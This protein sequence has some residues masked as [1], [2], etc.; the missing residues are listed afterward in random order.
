[1]LFSFVLN[2]MKPFELTVL[3]MKWNVKYS[4]NLMNHLTP[5]F[6]IM[7][8]ELAKVS[9]QVCVDVYTWEAY[10]RLHWICMCLRCAGRVQPKWLCMRVGGGRLVRLHMCLLIKMWVSCGHSISCWERLHNL[11]T[12]SSLSGLCC[13]SESKR[14]KVR[15]THLTVYLLQDILVRVRTR[16]SCKRVSFD[17]QPFWRNKVRSL[18]VS[19]LFFFS[20]A[21]G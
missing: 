15:E 11:C 18:L 4:S 10:Y 3:Y 12:V 13:N 16:M 1:M 5:M 20:C 6:V 17:S 8:V 21:S 14:E 9:L 2:I 7:Y 19:A